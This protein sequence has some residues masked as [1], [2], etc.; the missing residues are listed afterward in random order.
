EIS[1]FNRMCH[2]G[3]VHDGD[4]ALVPGLNFDVTAGNRNERA[5]VRY[6]VFAV[7]LGGRHLVV[8]SK[9]ELVVLHTENRISAPFVRIVGPAACAHSAAPLIGEHDFFP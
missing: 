2:V 6:T 7:A 8:T 3:E 4:A 9:G 1:D 5:V